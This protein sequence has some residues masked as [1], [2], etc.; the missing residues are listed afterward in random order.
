MTYV[1]A[2]RTAPAVY[3]NHTG[4]RGWMSS[5]LPSC[6]CIRKY[7][8]T[9][10]TQGL[11]EVTLGKGRGSRATGET[12][13]WGPFSFYMLRCSVVC[14]A[15]IKHVCTR[16]FG[17]LQHGPVQVTSEPLSEPAERHEHRPLR[18]LSTDFPRVP[19]AHPSVAEATREPTARECVLQGAHICVVLTQ[20]FSL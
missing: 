18:D 19:Q 3:T 16:C 14:M 10:R 17:R 4:I 9:G 1:R 20:S 12:G 7:R 6:V 8:T 5:G 2:L 11:T 15:Y 13:E